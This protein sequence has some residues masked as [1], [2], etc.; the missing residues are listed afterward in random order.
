MKRNWVILCQ[1]NLFIAITSCLIM[2]LS[3]ITSWASVEKAKN[4]IVL[5]VVDTSLSMAE[6]DALPMNRVK[7]FMK[8]YLE[9]SEIGDRLVVM[10]FDEVIKEKDKEIETYGDIKNIE[11]SIDEI[12]PGGQ[13]T[14]I[15]HA[16]ENL[17]QKVSDL[18]NKYPERRVTVYFL[19]DGKDDPPPSAKEQIRS[20]K[21]LLVDSF[22]DFK[23]R[24]TY[25][26]VLYSDPEALTVQ[27][28][29][30]IGKKTSIIASEIPPEGIIHRVIELE[31]SELNLGSMAK[32]VSVIK[33]EIVITRLINA[34]GE[35][36]RL[37]CSPEE[38]A[39]TRETPLLRRFMLPSETRLSP[40]SF[41]CESEGQRI[42]LTFSFPTQ[43]GIGHYEG[44]LKL[45]SSVKPIPSRINIGFSVLEDTGKKIYLGPSK[46]VLGRL[47][48]TR[49]IER[50]KVLKLNLKKLVNARGERISLTSS[51]P[52]VDISPKAIQCDK[53]GEK[54]IA[55]SFSADLS[56]GKRQAEIEISPNNRDVVIFPEK[57][58][59]VFVVKGQKGKTEENGPALLGKIF[60]F[61]SILIPLWIFWASFLRNKTLWSRREDTQEVK[62]IKLKG[63]IRSSLEGIGLPDHYLRFQKVWWGLI[64]GDKREKSEKR[65]TFQKR[66]DCRLPD[67]NTISVIFSHIP[68]EGTSQNSRKK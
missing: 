66:F 48:L 50:K 49:E 32:G 41:T 1:K 22:K 21:E 16:L 57:I 3:L 53:E 2:I 25:I 27:A 63:W 24:D 67:G 29:E 13:W 56:I 60:L 14:W 19:T 47:D 4:Q 39:D 23:Q 20:L 31:P 55:I 8:K 35:T 64:L 44:V 43:L 17:N 40:E 68:F 62:K 10:T 18:R 5:F 28:K 59:V 38:S 36:V 15:R 58:N 52:G 9:K 34:K 33:G 65:I 7:S 26:Y 42:S 11:K 54:E 30:E 45:E 46:L 37:T 6:K 61:F 51:L 12:K